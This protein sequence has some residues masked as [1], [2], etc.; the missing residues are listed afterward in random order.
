MPTHRGPWRDLD[1][2]V[3]HAVEDGIQEPWRVEEP[4]DERPFTI[5]T[6]LGLARAVATAAPEKRVALT[7]WA[8][9]RMAGNVLAGNIS[10][11]LAHQVLFE[12]A[13]RNGLPA[14][15]A[16]SIIEDAFRSN[17]RG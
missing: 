2:K 10:R 8:S 13:M 5:N 3:A 4:S 17:S 1:A 9:R 16:G 12:A 14:L 7:T 11:N 15:D 6:V